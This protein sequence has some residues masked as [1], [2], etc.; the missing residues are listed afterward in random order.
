M[1]DETKISKSKE[2]KAKIVAEFAEKV[3]KSKAM[4]FANYQGMTHKQLEELKRALKKVD[5]ELVVTKNR[6]LTRAVGNEELVKGNSLEGPTVT[7][8]AYADVVSPLKELAKTIKALKLPIV[9]FGILEGK[10]IDE[11]QVTKLATLP[12]REMLLAQFVGGLKSP[13]YG[14]HRALNWNIQKFVM[15]LNA[16]QKTKQA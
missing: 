8:F 12:S 9:K 16:I 5:S 11:S 1:K 3:Q 4:V 14:L 2:K 13:L 10:V 7:L 15:T 6:L